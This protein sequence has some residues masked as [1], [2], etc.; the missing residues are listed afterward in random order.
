MDYK[1]LGL[2][3][4]LEIHQQLASQ[5]KLFCN[6]LIPKKTTEG[7]QAVSSEEFSLETKRKLRAVAGE[8]GEYD[9]AALYEFLRGRAFNY[10]SNPESSCLVELDDDPPKEINGE[11]LRTVLQVCR[12]LDCEILD[13]IY[14]M[15]KTVID[16]SSVSGF[17]RTALAGMNGSIDT[18]FGTVP[19]AT[20]CIEED[21]APAVSREAG[22]VEYRL[23]RLGVPLIEIATSADVHSPAEAKETAERIGLLLRSVS[24]VRGIGSIRQDINI[25]IAGGERI[26]IKGFQELER[27]PQAVENEVNR[28]LA[29]LEIKD[30]LHKRGIVVF[31]QPKDVTHVFKN[32]RN[33]FLRKIVSENGKV[34]GA[35][36]PKFAGLLKK[37]CGDR[38]FGKELASYAEAYGYGIIH[39]DE[40]LEKHELAGEFV[41]LRE[42]LK[43]E[44]H[45]II[46]ITAGRN[47]AAA[48]NA[49]LARAK[50]CLIGI[51]KETRAADGLGSKYTRPLPGS[52]RM[53]PE[54][55]IPPVRITKQFLASVEVPKTLL[56]KEKELEKKMPR[57]LASQIV[58]STEFPLFEELSK[59][60]D[61]VLVATTLLSTIKDLRRKGYDTG[62]ITRTDMEKLFASISRDKIPKNSLH[63][64]LV[65]V[66]EGRAVK[67]A[68]EKFA[69]MEEGELKKVIADVAKSNPGKNESALMGIIMGR[70]GGRATGSEVLK[71][72]RSMKK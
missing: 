20:V 22:G 55:D 19:I 48:I 53:Y 45:D 68:E 52:E 29:L 66:I 6:C 4:G 54:T 24:V 42:E 9:P 23:D 18:A 60:A 3:V 1:K 8:M 56:E 12:L 31:V 67:D 7:R 33:N 64:A 36:L 15:R 21:S 10:K 2:K 14:V 70:I 43:P 40:D 26:E 41:K 39:S 63:D 44:E 16:G 30:E 59:K 47:P 13:E 35:V 27:I 62:K 46:V 38:T 25:S 69:P 28:Q 32:T 61:P 11:A 65:M 57:E 50:Q 51:P 37:Q 72:L 5:H 49:V 34:F 71:F 58:H 17:Q